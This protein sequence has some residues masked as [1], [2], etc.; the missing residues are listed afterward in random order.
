MCFGSERRSAS[1]TT[2]RAVS[3]GYWRKQAACDGHTDTPPGRQKTEAPVPRGGAARVC[4]REP[5]STPAR[6]TSRRG[7]LSFEWGKVGDTTDP[8]RAAANPF[9]LGIELGSELRFARVGRCD[10]QKCAVQPWARIE[11]PGWDEPTPAAPTADLIEPAQDSTS[12][13]QGPTNDQ[14]RAPSD[15]SAPAF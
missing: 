5:R 3:G 12:I 1:R 10:D 9:R 7:G 14:H 8:I 13:Q 6:S 11:P 15:L 4:K 2:A